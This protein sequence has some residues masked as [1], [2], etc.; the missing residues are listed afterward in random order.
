MKRKLSQPELQRDCETSPLCK[1]KTNKNPGLS[2]SLQR[3]SGSP[4]LSIFNYGGGIKIKFRVHQI[5][6]KNEMC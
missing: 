6:D 3:F 4:C 5:I 2:V 1:N